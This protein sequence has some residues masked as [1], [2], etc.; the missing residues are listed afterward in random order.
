M[1]LENCTQCRGTGWKLVPRPDGAAGTVAVPCDCGMQERAGRVMERARIPK[2]YENCDFESFETELADGRNYT[3]QNTLALKHAKLITQKFVSEYPGGDQAGLLLMGP[4]GTG[5]THLAIAALRMLITQG[6]SGY[7]CEYG[8][9]LREIQQSYSSE[10]QISE[11]K[12]LEPVLSVEVLVIDDLGCIKPSDWVRDTVGYI[13]NERYVQRSRDLTHP[14]CTII[15]TN[16][17][18]EVGQREVK[19]PNGRT[20]IVTDDAL[21]NRIGERM[22]SRLYEM[23][24]TVKIEPGTPDFRLQVRQAGRVKA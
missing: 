11:M 10:S 23:C 19:L 12:I 5:K 9:L 24:R 15:T 16:Y 21:W 22:R 14:R 20:S 18:D 8:K 3:A 13:L 17:F 4:P 6:H 2:H 7:F 1:A